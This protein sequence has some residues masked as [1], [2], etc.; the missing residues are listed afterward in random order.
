MNPSI[1]LQSI[2]FSIATATVFSGWTFLTE[3]GR[4]YPYIKIAIA[5]L[6]SLGVYRLIASLIIEASKKW[7]WFKK[8]MLGSYFLNGTYVGFYIGASGKIRYIVERFEQ[9][10]DSLVIRGKSFDDNL[11]YHANWTATSVNIDTKAG[12][13]SYMYECTPMKDSSN[14]NG[15]AIFSFI[16]KNQDSPANGLEGF[17]ADLHIGKRVRAKEIKVSDKC[18][19]DE[20]DALRK[21]KKLYIENKKF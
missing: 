10:I 17:S 7:T 20:K 2:S 18:S 15:V 12:K 3:I 4:S 5:L 1:K 8:I 9:D 21:A 6:I 11:N 14:H 19:L 13:I 16:R